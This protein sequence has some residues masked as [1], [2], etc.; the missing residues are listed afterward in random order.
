M[1]ENDNDA[2]TETGVGL[3]PVVEAS[4]EN[5]SDASD[6][7]GSKKGGKEFNPETPPSKKRRL[8][9]YNP[10]WE[11]EFSWIVKCSDFSNEKNKARC[12]LCNASINVGYDIIP[13]FFRCSRLYN[14]NYETN[15]PRFGNCKKK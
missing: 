4:N 1:S 14:K 15:H 6:V 8:C 7:R 11:K 10:E 12:K 13:Q 3:L 2:K 5:A 9:M